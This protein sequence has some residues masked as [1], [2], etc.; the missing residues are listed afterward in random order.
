MVHGNRFTRLAIAAILVALSASCSA[1][2]ANT[3]QAGKEAT[4]R[5]GK[6][7]VRDNVYMLVG[8]T[9]NA[10]IQVG[11]EGVL[12]VDTMGEGE[13]DAMIKTIKSLSDEPIRHI[14]NTHAHADHI[15]GNIRVAEAGDALFNSNTA[16][17]VNVP[18]SD[19]ESGS[20]AIYAHENAMF[21]MSTSE[22]QVPM[23]AWPTSTFFTPRKDLY[24]N[25]EA[26]ILFH[27]PN[28]HTDG[29][30]IVY[31]RGTDVIVTG[32]LFD[33]TRYPYID[34]DNGGSLQGIIDALNHI[35]AIAVPEALQ[36]G[37]TLIVPGNGRLCDESEVV[38]YRDML[39]IIQSMIRERINE[40]MTLAEVL[41]T[42]PTFG[43]DVRYGTSSDTWST[44]QF[45]ETVYREIKA[46]N[47]E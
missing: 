28:A 47:E 30:S 2:P 42:E 21:A 26:V 39:T 6:W 7:R 24:F 20:A 44:E 33:T 1:Q 14:I 23:D 19:P 45:V 8:D 22:P 27:Q 37:G 5:I 40:G 12:V 25:G 13:T 38:E 46:E 3:E 41:E 11:S 34:V 15:G 43:Y 35:I 31:F 4:D 36:E 16:I 29:D 18:P 10:V 32:D 9:S 17:N